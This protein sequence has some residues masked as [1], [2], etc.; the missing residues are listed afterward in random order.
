MPAPARPQ[1][2]LEHR[3]VIPLIRRDAFNAQIA[4]EPLE[5]LLVAIVLFPAG[6]IA[7]VA[8][9]QLARPTQLAPVSHRWQFNV[10]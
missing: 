6:E 4:H 7:D 10:H 5:A 9:P 8:G 2:T 3:R 1:R